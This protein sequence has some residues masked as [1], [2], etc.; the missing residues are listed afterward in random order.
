MKSGWRGPILVLPLV[1]FLGAFFFV[2]LIG[3]LRIAFAAGIPRI[4]EV[5][6]LALRN[7]V[8]IS[9]AVAVLSVALCVVPAYVLSRSRGRVAV[10]ART[11]VMIPLTFSGVVIGFLAIAVLGRV[12]AVPRF[13]EAVTGTAF[14]SA[15]AYTVTGLAIAYLYFEIPRAVFALESAFSAIDPELEHAAATL[16][17][18]RAE[19]WTRILLPLI[20]RELAAT[21]LLTFS[22]SLGSYGVA[23]MLSRKTTFLP[24][25]IFQ[26]FTGILDD[27]RAAFLSIVLV[28]ISIVCG[29]T[30]NLLIRQ[31]RR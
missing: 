27:Q 12:G 5:A 20:W 8:L 21:L 28:T 18:A 23:L 25:E 16:G 10:V 29:M 31:V 3:L 1:L 4:D 24:L 11:A 13:F 14:L 19:R 9:V 22:I 7:S 17:A 15:S 2:P 26:S 30:S 6:L